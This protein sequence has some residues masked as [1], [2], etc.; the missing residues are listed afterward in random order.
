MR[1]FPR[2]LSEEQ[3]IFSQLFSR[4]C[5]VINNAFGILAARQRIFSK[6]LKAS[7]KN[8]EKYTLTRTG[9][10]NYLCL[11]G[12]PSCYPAGFVDSQSESGE[13]RPGDWRNLANETNVALT[14]VRNV[15]SCHNRENV[16]EMRDGIMSYVNGLGE[17]EWQVAQREEKTA[18]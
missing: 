18:Y 17:D 2:K 13:I 11:T 1:P 15:R 16:V 14:N 3:Q 5:Q 7:S 6:P 10:Q 4:A 9:L 12:N 8:V